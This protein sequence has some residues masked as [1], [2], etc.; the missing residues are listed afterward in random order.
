MATPTYEPARGEYIGRRA[1][2]PS[3]ATLTSGQWWYNTTE[4]RFKYFDG[5]SV[6]VFEKAPAEGTETLVVA[7]AGNYHLSITVSGISVINYILNIRVNTNPV[8]DP[9]TPTCI[10]KIGN[11]VGMTLIGVGGG[12]TLT[13]TVTVFGY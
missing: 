2:D 6:I 4:N 11:V 8:V 9:G 5:T 3:V 12:T 10:S 1:S 13:G 7:T